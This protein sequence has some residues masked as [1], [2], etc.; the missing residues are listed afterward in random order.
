MGPFPQ[1]EVE[2]EVLH[3]GIKALLNGCVQSVDLVD[4]EDV[5]LLERSEHA[6]EVAFLLD[7][8]A[9]GAADIYGHLLGEDVRQGGFAQARRSVEKDV[10]QRF[11]PLP[12]SLDKHFEVADQLF[13]AYIIGEVLGPQC[14]IQHLFSFLDSL[15]LKFDFVLVTGPQPPEVVEKLLARKKQIRGVVLEPRFGTLWETSVAVNTARSFL[16]KGMPVAFVPATDSVVGHRLVFFHLA[17]MIKTGVLP[18]EAV[19]AVTTVPAKFLGLEGKVGVL[20]KGVEANFVAFDSDPFGA[21]ARLSS[22]YVAGKR[23]F[24]D[25]AETGEVSGESIR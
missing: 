12:C 20:K 21:N 15:P 17:Q 14:A 23:V 5:P 19:R 3:R 6:G 13:L 25:D 22:V 8:G 1:H 9:G 11:F 24:H 2:A 7:Y 10:V 18:D 16:E 4:E